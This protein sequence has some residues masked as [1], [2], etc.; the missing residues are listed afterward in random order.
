MNNFDCFKHLDV[1]EYMLVDFAKLKNIVKK[2]VH[3]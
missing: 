2:I 3:P 1:F